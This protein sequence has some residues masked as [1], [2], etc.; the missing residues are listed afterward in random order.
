MTEK[1]VQCCY[2]AKKTCF[3]GEL[4]NSPEFC[5]S[6]VAPEALAEARDRLDD[7]EIRKYAQD[8]AKTWRGMAGKNRVEL[9]MEY[10]KNRGYK[11]L[12]LA[13]CVGL[14]KEAELLAN[15][16]INGG[17]EVISASCMCGALS[18][19]DVALPEED[20]IV[21]GNRQPMCNPIGQAAVLDRGGSE[22]NIML[23]LCVGDDV[24]FIKH[25]KAPVTVI[26]VKD[27]AL[28]HNP[29]GALYTAG[30][31]FS[32]LNTRRPKKIEK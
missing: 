14:S 22:L 8:V 25:S 6:K 27:F 1:E 28:A 2:C 31:L 17:F 30:G 21:S 7:P 32:R 16:L 19:D 15:A 11:K 29:L 24:L 13:F 12:G 3:L 18:S 9:T 5:P 20:K 10:A 26:G 23:G 4:S